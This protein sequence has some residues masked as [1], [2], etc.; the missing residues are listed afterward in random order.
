[1]DYNSCK[2]FQI[3]FITHQMKI[4]LTSQVFKTNFELH[5]HNILDWATYITSKS[6]HL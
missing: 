1:M 3:L 6:P 2:D 4:L 5:F